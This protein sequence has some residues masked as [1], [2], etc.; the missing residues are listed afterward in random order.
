ML[1]RCLRLRLS[2]RLL[3]QIVLLQ[4]YCSSISCC[5][6]L[7][8]SSAFF[9]AA[10]A[11]FPFFFFAPPAVVGVSTS[12]GVPGAVPA[13]DAKAE[14]AGIDTGGTFVSIFGGAA[15]PAATAVAAASTAEASRPGAASCSC[16][17]GLSGLR[18]PPCFVF[19]ADVV[20]LIAG[21]PRTDATR[22]PMLLAMP[23]KPHPPSGSAT[24]GG[25]SSK[26]PPGIPLAAA[27]AAP[28]A[29]S[30]LGLC[31][32]ASPKI[33]T[34]A[35][36]TEP[37]SSPKIET[38]LSEAAV[39]A[40]PAPRSAIPSPTPI[41]GVPNASFGSSPKTDMLWGGVRVPKTAEA[42]DAAREMT[43][44]SGGG[45]SWRADGSAGVSVG[46]ESRRTTGDAGAG[47]ASGLMWRGRGDGA[48]AS[49]YSRP[50]VWGRLRE[51][52]AGEPGTGSEGAMLFLLLFVD[53]VSL[54]GAAEDTLFL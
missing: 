42:D 7:S 17:D 36:A 16:A 45:V 24:G 26:N 54:G 12:T 4:L 18:G 32:G 29:P 28:P 23:P 43:G 48:G 44:A 22:L 49:T 52:T 38:G 39:P 10:V 41:P 46:A 9:A 3:P 31:A 2:L 11:F 53:L 20:R 15:F 14:T 40:I 37:S 1:G 33:D 8:S 25:G 19:C 30:S 47:D 34:G 50:G 35:P 51:E 21:D 6:C 27:A 5:L 13:A